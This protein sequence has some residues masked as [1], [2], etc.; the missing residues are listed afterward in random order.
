MEMEFEV[1]NQITTYVVKKVRGDG[2]C[3]F[4]MLSL[5]MFGTQ[6]HSLN[7]RTD[8][9]HHVLSYYDS[10]K[11]SIAIGEHSEIVCPSANEYQTYML[12][13]KNFGDFVEV[14]AASTIFQKRIITIRNGAIECDIGNYLLSKQL[15]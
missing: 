9:V 4:N 6:E 3:L 15:L 2:A 7:I 10:Y 11:H 12:K 14:T 1:N 13:P 5:A 8:I